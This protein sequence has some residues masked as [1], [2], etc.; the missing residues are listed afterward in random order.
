MSD[1]RYD[2]LTVPD[3]IA[4]NC[5]YMNLPDK[6]HVLLHCTAE[7][8]PESVKVTDPARVS[9]PHTPDKQTPR[10]VHLQSW[11]YTCESKNW[12][13]GKSDRFSSSS[14]LLS[15]LFE[16]PRNNWSE[17]PRVSLQP[18]LSVL[19]TGDWQF[20]VKWPFVDMTAK[21]CPG[22]TGNGLEWRK[23]A[24]KRCS[25]RINTSPRCYR[26]IKP[27]GGEK[28]WWCFKRDLFYC[29]KTSWLEKRVF[30]LLC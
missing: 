6:G 28:G 27:G 21:A 12:Q 2:K 9:Q 8:Y 24:G 11:R 17:A 14:L 29:F 30:S 13:T 3:D 5:I 1:H 4:A 26:S 10:H 22:A 23:G 7:E 16:P 19:L 15:I 25:C 20:C 18:Q